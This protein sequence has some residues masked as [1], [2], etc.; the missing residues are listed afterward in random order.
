MKHL[1][2]FLIFVFLGCSPGDCV[3][4]TGVII[5]KEITVT[6][7]EKIIVR[8]GIGLVI[9]QGPEY[10]VAIRSGAN[11]IND[12]ETTISGTTLTL[13]DNTTCNWVRDYGQTTVFVTAPNLTEIYSKTNQTIT[14][15]GVL[16]FPN[17]SLIATDNFD[18]SGGSGTGDFILDINNDNLSIVNNY[19]SNFTISGQTQNL[20]IAIYEG[21]G[22]M[23][24]ENLIAKKINIYHRGSNKAIVHPLDELTGDIYNIGNVI[25]VS[26]PTVAKVTEHYRGKL[27]FR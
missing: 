2:V 7:F 14:S 22:I 26:K 15:N 11:L 19:V 27:I 5:T 20:K 17:L 13:K 21:N 9:T 25:C 1:I 23:N 3:K 6:P 10:K 16:T 24:T 12:I 18:Q 8:P 4:S